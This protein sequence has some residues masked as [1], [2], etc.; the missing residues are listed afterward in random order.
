M[1]CRCEHRGFRSRAL[2]ET[3]YHNMTKHLGLSEAH[4]FYRC[5]DGAWHWETRFKE[6]A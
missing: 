2:A 1:A 3:V 6:I 4:E 5:A